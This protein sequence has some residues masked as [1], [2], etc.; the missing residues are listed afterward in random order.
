MPIRYVACQQYGVCK[1]QEADLADRLKK[2][3]WTDCVASEYT[4]SAC[5][6]MLV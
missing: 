1:N 6:S 5:P 2:K 3:C 4:R